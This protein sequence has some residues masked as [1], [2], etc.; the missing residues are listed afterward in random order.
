MLLKRHLTVTLVIAVSADTVP[1]F[2]GG[3]QKT[4]W[5]TKSLYFSPNHLI[6]LKIQPGGATHS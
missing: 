1:L 6:H 5:W 3:G 2:M 4:D